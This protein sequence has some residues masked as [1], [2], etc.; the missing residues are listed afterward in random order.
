MC[1]GAAG[2]N[3]KFRCGLDRDPHHAGDI[4][5]GVAQQCQQID[6]LI[7]TQPELFHPIRFGDQLVFVYIVHLGWWSAFTKQLF[8]I[9]VLG[10]NPHPHIW[11]L[12]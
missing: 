9:L 1:L 10:D 8:E 4:V 3:N 6:D 7:R 2:L 12:G 11:V 5:R